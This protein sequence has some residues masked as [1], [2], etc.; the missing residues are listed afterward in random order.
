MTD[1]LSLALGVETSGVKKGTD[2]LNK[3]GNAADSAGESAKGFEDKV[4][5]S[6]GA[7]SGL[8]GKS[9]PKVNSGLGKFVKGLKP[10]KNATQLLAFQAQDLAV[11]LSM[12]T[13]SLVAFG[14]QAPQAFSAFGPSGAVL[15]AIAGVG[16]ALAGPLMAAFGD[17][18]Q[19][20]SSF[21]QKIDGVTD[22]LKSTRLEIN[23]G[24][25]ALLTK[26]IREADEAYQDL[27]T[28]IGQETQGFLGVDVAA[29][30]AGAKTAEQA[31]DQAVAHENEQFKRQEALNELKR[32]EIEL[33]LQAGETLQTDVPANA[34]DFEGFSV[35]EFLADQEAERERSRKRQEDGLIRQLAREDA[36]WQAQSEK[37]K[38][39][40]RQ[41]A[42]FKRQMQR[43][44]LST[45]ANLFG[46]LAELAAQGGEESFTLYK[47]MAQAQAGVSAGLAILN[48]LAA[49]TGNPI[50]NGAMAV[51]IG[52]LAA[53]QIATI[54]QQTYSGARAMGGQVSGGNSYLV[55]EMGPEII[56]MGAQGGF[57]TPNHKLG[58]ESVTIVNQIGNNVKP[59][60]RAEVL[61]MRGEITGM[62]MSAMKGARR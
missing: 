54:E 21:Q 41:E 5:K 34:Y 58:G 56:T 32:E 13:S 1:K 23:L 40:I 59:N 55:G 25:Q 7:A 61:S 9:L 14:Q 35:S 8:G 38:Q 33:N 46:N 29:V 51:T 28:N 18:E 36:L 62:V 47:R 53:A 10:A 22:S 11:Q 45:T 49:P 60:V 37:N 39:R 57:V 4:K 31:M 15:G 48:A 12:G 27:A 19:A 16:F 6:D 17:T 26:Q 43:N 50:L 44:E 2:E 24:A 3:F 52:A 20:A 30:K 42:E